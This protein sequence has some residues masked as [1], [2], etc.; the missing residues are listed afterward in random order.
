[1]FGALHE[2]YGEGWERRLSWPLDMGELGEQRLKDYVERHMKGGGGWPPST[3]EIATFKRLLDGI[4][5]S[6]EPEKLGSGRTAEKSS[7][8]ADTPVPY[9]MADLLALIDERIGKLEGRQEKPHLRSLKIRII[10]AINDPRYH[11]MFSNNT[12]SDAHFSSSR[13]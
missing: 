1:M 9:R 7:V 3:E 6:D 2:V 11:F 4:R 13:R 10:S 8:T 5:V 12:I